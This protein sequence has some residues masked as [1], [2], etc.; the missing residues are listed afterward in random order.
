MIY[1]IRQRNQ[2][3][4]IGTST[5]VN[6]R[7]KTLQTGNPV[8]LRVKAILP[9]DHK[10]ETGLHEMFKHLR[11][12]GEWFRYTDE[13]KW[14]IRV[15]QKH[16]T[17]SNIRW[18]YDTALKA[19]LEEKSRRLGNAHKLSQRIKRIEG[20]LAPSSMVRPA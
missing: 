18:L 7:V 10:T 9:G 8:K 6:D 20:G 13:L 17:R 2:F 19:R 3:I 4:K 12:A 14:F 15:I 11:V 1:F 5:S 16:P